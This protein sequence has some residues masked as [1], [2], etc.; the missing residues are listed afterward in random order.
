MAP[1]VAHSGDSVHRERAS[2]PDAQASRHR[3]G[4]RHRRQHAG[5]RRIDRHARTLSSASSYG[6]ASPRTSTSRARR[7][8]GMCTCSP[9]A[10]REAAVVGRRDGHGSPNRTSGAD[11]D[12]RCA[13]SELPVALADAR[14]ALSVRCGASLVRRGRD[15]Q[16]RPDSLESYLNAGGRVFAS[17]YHY[18]WFSGALGSGQSYTAPMGWGR[19]S[20][21]WSDGATGGGGGGLDEGHR[22]QSST[23]R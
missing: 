3:A 20:R 8:R 15:V 12:G 18:A 10:R 13:R 6:W 14:P 9:A 7:R 17:H 1:V 4:R 11:A 23:R 21:Q 2:G 22:R 5:H 19:R 16:R